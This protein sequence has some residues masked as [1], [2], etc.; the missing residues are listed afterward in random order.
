MNLLD[1]AFGTWDD[2]LSAAADDVSMSYYRA[3]LDPRTATWGQR[4]TAM[5][6]HPFARLLPRWAAS[7]I[8]MPADQLPGD[9]NMPRVQDPSFGASERFVVSPGREASGIFHMP[10]GQ[11]SNPYSPFFRAGHED[12]VHGNPTPFL[13]GAAEHVIELLP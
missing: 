13:P 7:R 10:G 5:I 11:V 2:L 8:G 9:S 1:P 12:W 3:G 6:D 4:N